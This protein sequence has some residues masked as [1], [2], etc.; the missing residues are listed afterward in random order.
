MIDI[1]SQKERDINKIIEISKLHKIFFH[2]NLQIKK[3]SEGKICGKLISF[4]TRY[5]SKINLDYS[6]I[7]KGVYNIIL[8][9]KDEFFFRKLIK[10]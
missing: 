5:S 2:E 10:H 3:I 1:Y 8:S 7:S 4:K 6:T 9:S